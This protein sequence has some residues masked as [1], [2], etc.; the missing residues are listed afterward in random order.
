MTDGISEQFPI[1]SSFNQSWTKTSHE[2]RPVMNQDQSWTR[3]SLEPRPVLNQ[4]K[5]GNLSLWMRNVACIS[6]G[7]YG[8]LFF[9]VYKLNYACLEQQ[10]QF[11]EIVL[12]KTSIS[13]TR[14]RR[15]NWK[16]S[17]LRNVACG[18]AWTYSVNV[19]ILTWN[20]KFPKL[21]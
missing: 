7:W 14:G 5:W 12:L 9:M 10:N 19:K 18:W 6:F 4:F 3:T 1:P 17:V 8:T 21:K 11:N 16:F 2:P 15:S 20:N 13:N